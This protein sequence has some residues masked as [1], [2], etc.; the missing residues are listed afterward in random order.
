M[1]APQGFEAIEGWGAGNQFPTPQRPTSAPRQGLQALPQPPD[2]NKMNK[3]M[4]LLRSLG[5]QPDKMTML[6]AR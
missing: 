4:M 6:G 2:I 3:L 5:P 1:P